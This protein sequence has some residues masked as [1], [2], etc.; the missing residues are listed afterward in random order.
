MPLKLIQSDMFRK[1]LY[2]LDPGFI[3]PDVKLIKQIIHCVYNHTYPQIVQYIENH[4][5]SV[6]L[7]T[8]FWTARNR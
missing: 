7:T 1:F 8:D 4:A 5:V 6:N 2:D 3:A